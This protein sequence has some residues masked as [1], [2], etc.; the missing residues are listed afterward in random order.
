MRKPRAALGSRRRIFIDRERP[1]RAVFVRIRVCWAMRDTVVGGGDPGRTYRTIHRSEGE[2]EKE[3]EGSPRLRNNVMRL[4][5]SR[6]SSFFVRVMRARYVATSADG[7]V[8]LLRIRGGGCGGGAMC[9]AG[10]GD[11]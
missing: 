3:V 4:V 7:R 10:T 5:R 2:G 8:L 9:R 1:E 11:R 6:V